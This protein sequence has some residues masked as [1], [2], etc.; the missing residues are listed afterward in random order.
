MKATKYIVTSEKNLKFKYGKKFTAIQQALKKL[1]K[2]DAARGIQT[3]VLYIDSPVSAKKAGIK[4]VHSTSPR[5]C[6][7]AIDNLYS[8]QK[9]DYIA[10]LGA[11]DII[12]FQEINN[13]AGDDG[14]LTV[15]SD[16]PYACDA[17]YG[18]DVYKFIGP[19]RVVGRIPDVPQLNQVA[20]LERLLNNVANHK[21]IDA[22]RYRKYFSVSAKVWRRST[23][24][25]LNNM[26]GHNTDLLVSPLAA[27]K[28]G[29]HKTHL[30]PLT[31]F[32]NC[33]GASKD[34]YY[35]GQ[36][37]SSYPVALDTS[38]LAKKIGYGTVV[39][40]ECCYG[41]ELVDPASNS[42]GNNLTHPRLSIANNYLMN[43]A[44]AFLG[45]STIAYGPPAS[46]GL[47]DLITQFFIKN[48][49]EGMSSGRALA[50]A[51]QRFISE[52]GPDLDPYELKTL[53]QF[54]LLG[55]PSVRPTLP[56][57]EAADS[58]AG[59]TTAND[60]KKMSMKGATIAQNNAP[61][62]LVARAS[63]L[64]GHEAV[65]KLMK[66]LRLQ[67]VN[68]VMTFQ[69]KPTSMMKSIAAKRTIGNHAKFHTF[70]NKKKSSVKI[71][72]RSVK[73]E[74]NTVLVVKEMGKEILGWRYYAAK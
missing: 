2:A 59:N 4:S 8:K 61:S 58:K 33:H 56:D 53:A 19:T 51:R 5:D 43:D 16:L 66:Q 62:K 7:M 35:Y 17:P 46:Q 6:K 49:L 42:N 44:I 3:K 36:Q 50:E 23:Q 15:P 55:D 25:S 63:S 57:E 20:Y 73:I 67:K 12:P 27:P 28:N 24:L 30:K 26:F 41:A 1:I 45:S 60:R 11:Q 21:S 22:D 40:A 64:E 14:D 9:P 65:K 34:W 47:A 13:P 37:G 38:N 52:S 70:M 72:A 39:A 48:I 32:F 68:S 29:Y 31:H 10:I 74:A 69:V 71:G 18:K 54:Y